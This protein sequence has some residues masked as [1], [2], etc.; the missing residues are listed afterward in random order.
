MT[1]RLKLE[2][3]SMDYALW[4]ERLSEIEDLLYDEGGV[5]DRLNSCQ[6]WYIKVGNVTLLKSYYTVVAAIWDSDPTT[7]YDFS[8]IV[9]GYTATTSQHISKFCDKFNAD[10]IILERG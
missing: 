7:C 1:K 3:Y 10:K 4:N 9:Y 8:R 5:W 6:A 2:K